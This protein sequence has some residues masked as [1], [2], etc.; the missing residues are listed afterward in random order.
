MTSS[1]IRLNAVC[2]G[3]CKC[4]VLQTASTV[5]RQLIFSG[6]SD[7]LF[8]LYIHTYIYIYVF[9]YLLIQVNQFRHKCAGCR[10]TGVRCTARTRDILATGW[11][12]SGS[13]P[14]G[15]KHSAPTQTGPGAQA[16]SSIVGIGSF[17]EI[18]WPGVASP[19][20]PYL[21]LTLKKE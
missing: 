7:V 5:Y 6:N 20:R 19:P 9:I 2:K 4:A 8:T 18:K 14:D 15:G 12:V 3:R 11:T 16:A 17:S 10:A 1:G 21:E 13:N